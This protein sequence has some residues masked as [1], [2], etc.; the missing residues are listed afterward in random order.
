MTRD[1]RSINDGWE[2]RNELEHQP[3]DAVIDEN[4]LV[5]DAALSDPDSIASRRVL[6]QAFEQELDE[7]HT[8]EGSSYFSAKPIDRQAEER[9]RREERHLM[10]EVTGACRRALAEYGMRL[11]TGYAESLGVVKDGEYVLRAKDREGRVFDV[12]YGLDH[13]NQLVVSGGKQN[14]VERMGQAVAREVLKEREKY[15]SRMQ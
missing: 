4:K 5:V 9:A 10:A 14:L 3:P 7:I 12:K 1:D 6:A 2:T 8:P 13:A 15:L 11:E